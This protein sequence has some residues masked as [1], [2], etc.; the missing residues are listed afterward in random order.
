MAFSLLKTLQTG[1]TPLKIPKVKA[2]PKA[3]AASATGSRAPPGGPTQLYRLPAAGVR[4]SMPASK[5]YF[6]KNMEDQYL[7][8][9]AKSLQT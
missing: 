6:D 3:R 4:T 7:K 2:K 8:L 1:M 9:V 5:A